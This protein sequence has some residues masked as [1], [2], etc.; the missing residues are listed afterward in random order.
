M[1]AMQQDKLIG[2]NAHCRMI[3]LA[4]ETLVNEK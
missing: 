3:Q 4:K 2:F 1:L